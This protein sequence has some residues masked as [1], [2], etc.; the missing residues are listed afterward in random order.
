[1]TRAMASLG[2]P[3]PGHGSRQPL[4]R[5]NWIGGVEPLVEEGGQAPPS[6]SF[7]HPRPGLGERGAGDISLCVAPYLLLSLSLEEYVIRPSGLCTAR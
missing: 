3:A 6:L 5:W 4:R 1:M 7:L 2:F